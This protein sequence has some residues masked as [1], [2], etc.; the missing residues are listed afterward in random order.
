M[1]AHARTS[2]AE[3]HSPEGEGLGGALAAAAV[4]GEAKAAARAALE[5]EALASI[6]R[7][8][9]ELQALLDDRPAPRSR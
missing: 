4:R 5:V 7:D 3:I 6:E 2:A 8:L 1:Q 9:A